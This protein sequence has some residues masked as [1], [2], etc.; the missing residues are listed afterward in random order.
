MQCNQS[1]KHIKPDA[2][3][4]ARDGHRQRQAVVGAMRHAWGSYVMYAWGHDELDPALKVG[5]DGF[6]GLGATVCPRPSQA[7]GLLGLGAKPYA[8]G[9]KPMD[10]WMICLT[11][12]HGTGPRAERV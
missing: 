2:E 6:G 3:V 8:L 12:S 9:A 1:F 4:R 5:K 7:S 11:D 10:R